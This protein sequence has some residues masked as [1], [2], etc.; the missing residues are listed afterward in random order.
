MKKAERGIFLGIL[1]VSMA[2][3]ISGCSTPRLDEKPA[4]VCGKCQTVWV[5]TR[6]VGRGG[7]A[8]YR[9]DKKMV[10]PDCEKAAD[11]YFSSGKL[12]PACKTCGD[13]LV[14]CPMS[15]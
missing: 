3:M 5:R 10:C 14:V 12:D 4:V 11:S 9:R 2:A 15:K 6:S 13:G 8:T 1:A 7:T